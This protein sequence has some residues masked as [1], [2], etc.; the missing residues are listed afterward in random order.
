MT[1]EELYEWNRNGVI[2]GPGESEE[3]FAERARETRARFE[4]GEW[5]PKPHWD[6]V[7]HHLREL[8]DFEPAYVP[9]FYSN[10]GLA[11]WEGAAAWIEGRFCEVQLRE[12]LRKGS[13]L[14][15]YRREEI[16]GHEAVHAAR[17]AFEEKSEEFF[18]Y[19]TSDKKWRK[20][21]GP[22]FERPWEAWLLVGVLGV[23]AFWPAG[24]LA[25]GCLAAIG[26]WRL[27]RM[28]R[29]LAKAGKRLEKAGVEKVR[30]VL[31]RMT[32][33]EIGKLAKGAD[34]QEVAGS[35]LRWRL[36]R[37]GYLNKI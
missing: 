29:R 3:A 4:R 2:P 8:F 22:I 25:A 6:W 26:F 7:R 21:L 12:G 31:F 37:L 10:K 17:C 23:G 27:G 19:M 32:D 35:C 30:A 33:K 18:A 11:V 34:L 9:V 24:Y 36:I 1:D 14:G 28:H 20:V 15:L 13:Y 5:I 16:L